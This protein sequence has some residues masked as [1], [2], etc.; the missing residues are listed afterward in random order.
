[1]VEVCDKVV[2]EVTESVVSE[3]EGREV[4]VVTVVVTTAVVGAAVVVVT[5]VMGEVVTVEE[6]TGILTD[7]I[8]EVE[9]DD[10]GGAEVSLELLDSS[11][12]IV[13]I[14]AVVEREG[15]VTTVTIDVEVD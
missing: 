15:L 7:L 3:T 4:L 10:V 11:V 13:D 9:K 8:I 2:V 12:V 6:A 5:T 1:M 14:K